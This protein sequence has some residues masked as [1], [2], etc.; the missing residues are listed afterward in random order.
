MG[1]AAVLLF[2]STFVAPCAALQVCVVEVDYVEDLAKLR[3]SGF[4]AVRASGGRMGWSC[5]IDLSRP[6]LRA[7]CGPCLPL[8][9]YLYL[10]MSSMDE[11]LRRVHAEV[12]A[13]AFLGVWPS[14][15]QLPPPPI[16][17]LLSEGQQQSTAGL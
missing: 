17:L 2:F 9:L 12:R 11:L 1:G 16:L 6:Q 5:W 7:T 8:Q 13:C 3:A 14:A 4:D 15:P 10:G